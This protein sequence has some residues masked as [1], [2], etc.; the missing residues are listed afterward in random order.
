MMKH[1]RGVVVAALALLLVGAQGLVMANRSSDKDERKLKTR[2]SGLNEPPAVL[3]GA[4]GLFEATINDDESGFEYTLTYE[5][6]EA[7][8][9]QSHI[10]IGQALVN[11]G[12]SIWLCETA[13]NP[14]PAAVAAA[15][16]DCAGPNSAT[17]TGTVV[18]A[19]VIGPNGQ[20]VSPG[21]F[22]EVLNA[23][24]HRVAYVNVHSVRSPGGEIRGQLKLDKGGDSDDQ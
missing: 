23:M 5:D 6:L 21:E 3:T 12:I 19:Q 1:S 16:P 20:G 14:A 13:L 7:P 15:T 17:V 24:R 9:T 18:P 8:V 10:H 4:R 2:L 11:G 22:A